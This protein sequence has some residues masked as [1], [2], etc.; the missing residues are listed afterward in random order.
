MLQMHYKN[1]K[2][3][4]ARPYKSI[5]ISGLKVFI[6][7][8]LQATLIIILVCIVT[9]WFIVFENFFILQICCFFWIFIIIGNTYT[10]DVLQIQYAIE[11]ANIYVFIC[12]CIQ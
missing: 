11:S 7:E 12:I 10:S 5:D 2:L 6:F 8:Y 1:T 4:F 3:L 9:V